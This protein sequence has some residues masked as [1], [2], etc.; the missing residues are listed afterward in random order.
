[1]GS[2][3]DVTLLERHTQ[4]AALAAAHRDAVSG[5]GGVVLVSGEAGIGKT[6]LVR[7]FA[8]AADADADVRW[9]LCDDLMTPRP[10][11]PFRD[12]FAHLTGSCDLTEFLEAVLDELTGPPQPVLA[13]VEDA[14]W[15]DHATLEAIRF[16]GRRIDRLGALLVLTYRD[17]EVPADHPLR[18]A[19]GAIPP[20][21]RRVVQLEALS[22]DA[23]AQL[24]SGQP[25]V[26]Q[27]YE[28]TGGNPFFVTEMLAHPESPVPLSV[29]DAVMARVGRLGGPG[30]ACAEAASAVPG[31]AELWLLEACGVADG[32]DEA[33][34]LGVLRPDGPTVAYSHELVRRVVERSLPMRRRAQVNGRILEA[35]AARDADPARLA[36]HAV[37]A[38]HQAAVARYAPIAARRAAAVGADLEAFEHYQ[39]A[40]RFGATYS[41][42]ELVEL[43]LATAAVGN[44]LARLD[45][46]CDA[47]ER[48]V[49]VSR[50]SDDQVSLGRSLTLLANLEWARGRGSH[51]E[52]AADAAVQALEGVVGGRSQLVRAYGEKARLALV[53]H[54]TDDAI[55]WGDKAVA[56][57][58]HGD[59]PPPVGVLVTVGSARL[60]RDPD[61]S[62]LLADALQTALG[63]RDLE[64]AA[65]AY[66][67][68]S[69]ELSLYM[70]YSAAGQYIEEGVRFCDVHDLLGALDHMMVV[71]ARWRL[72]QGRWSEA[73]QDAENTPRSEGATRTIADLVHGLVQARRGERAAAETLNRASTEAEQAAEAQLLVPA[74]LAT[75][76]LR[77]LD[78]D[79]GG[80]AAALAPVIDV[81]TASGVPRWIG[82]AALWRKRAAGFL[83]AIPDGAAEP[84]ALQ[85]AGQWNEAAAAWEAL[86]RPYEQADALAGAPKP[87]AL[88]AALEMLDRLG[89]VPRAAMVRR[90]LADLGVRSVPRGPRS[91]TL[92]SPAGLTRRQ[93]EVL[94]L[95]AEPLTYRAIADRLH[96]SIKTVDHHASA[97]RA[98]LGVGTRSEAVEAGRRLGILG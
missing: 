7:S 56:L 51:A 27:L 91:P 84:Y 17:D 23:V 30:R 68:L 38:D 3:A 96:V 61:D 71:R 55:A 14:H 81:V 76:E 45:E 72:E 6:A 19:L 93:T 37:H 8:A 29:Q 43:L 53:D 95:L 2:L 83:D 21:N 42:D 94:A 86:G 75:A 98:K 80:V 82:E 13:I 48:A 15:A 92:A 33:V 24:A 64:S 54:R 79:L 50:A 78:G 63:Q 77:W 39:R 52:Q 67:N 57:A 40:L 47:I 4:L 34:R 46:A 73:V 90:R 62:G 44:R 25:H 1:M 20:A 49:E 97:I 41:P 88:L 9:G 74:A 69:D 66:V 11:G 32:L 85:L 16:L 10:L 36:H 87:D 18:L 58:R 12:M 26:D 60:Q 28:A 89:A 31:P 5:Q 22:R 35:L 70:R 59:G 65:R